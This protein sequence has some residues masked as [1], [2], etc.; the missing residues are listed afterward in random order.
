VIK[1]DSTN[2]D[3]FIIEK[4]GN[5]ITGNEIPAKVEIKIETMTRNV[6]KNLPHILECVKCK[7]KK[8]CEVKKTPSL[9]SDHIKK[10]YENHYLGIQMPKCPFNCHSKFNDEIIELNGEDIIWMRETKG[11][12]ISNPML[13]E[14]HQRENVMRK[15]NFELEDLQGVDERDV[16]VLRLHAYYDVL[17]VSEARPDSMSISCGFTI[18]KCNMIIN[19]ALNL[20]N[21]DT[22]K[23]KITIQKIE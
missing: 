13:R 12:G 23:E 10:C 14:R 9:M 8:T 2:F 4:S 18:N 6:V 17:I 22:K 1:I 19:S 15:Y 20:L 21:T 7:T 11:I 3:E 5:S 16:V